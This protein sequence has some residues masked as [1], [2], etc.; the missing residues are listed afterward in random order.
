MLPQQPQSGSINKPAPAITLLQRYHWKRKI[1]KLLLDDF[2]YNICYSRWLLPC[3]VESWLRKV[4]ILFS[5]GNYLQVSFSSGTTYS[6]AGWNVEWDL[7]KEQKLRPFL[8]QGIE[9]ILKKED[10][11]WGSLGEHMV[12]EKVKKIYVRNL[13]VYCIECCLPSLLLWR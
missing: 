1:G 6:L 4:F 7:G 5:S 13:Q 2:L 3:T 11:T 8:T 12:E 9:K 10:K